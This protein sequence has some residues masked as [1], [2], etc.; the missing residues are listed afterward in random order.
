MLYGSNC[1]FGFKSCLKRVMNPSPVLHA[2]N[3]IDFT[4]ISDF[5]IAVN[6]HVNCMQYWARVY[7]TNLACKD[8]TFNILF[9][10][11]TI[12]H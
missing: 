8:A 9:E 10:I 6:N 2:V 12:C 4:A 5:F 11:M 3:M 1:H 7:G